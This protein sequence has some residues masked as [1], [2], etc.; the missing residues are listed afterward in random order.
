MRLV[1]PHCAAAY[2]VPPSLLGRSRTVRCARCGRDWVEP[3]ERTGAAEAADGGTD[4]R[5]AAM[6]LPP[7]PGG[8]ARRR[9]PAW[10]GK[11]TALRLGWVASVLALGI[12]IWGAVAWRSGVM[13]AWPPSRRL[14]AT[15]GLSVDRASRDAA[16]TPPVGS[17]SP[18]PPP[19]RGEE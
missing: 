1:C 7:P 11:V 5:P 19:A 3:G 13:H 4:P 18:R 6:P 9:L 17:P 8:P 2:E 16:D 12:G 14:Y 15:L 10:R